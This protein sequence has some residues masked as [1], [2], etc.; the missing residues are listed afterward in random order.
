MIRHAKSFYVFLIIALL[1]GTIPVGLVPG[2]AEAA[3]AGRKSM[4]AKKTKNA[5]VI[6]GQL[7]DS[8]W[9]IDQPLSVRTGD[10]VFKESTF[11]L[12]WDNQYLYIGVKADDDTLV[13]N[14]AGYWFEQDNI[15]LFFD[16]TNHRSAPFASE[17]MQVGFV[18]QPGS[19]TP[20]FHFG[21]ALNNHSGKD[22]KKILHAIRT[23]GSGWTLE[24][25]VPW[26][27]LQLDPRRNKQFGLE[28]G[29]TDRY[30]AADSAKQR[31]S[32]WSA[33]NTTSFWNDT[34]GYGTVTLDDG[35]P[36]TGAVNPVLLHETFD[37][38]PS[39]QL[40]VGW[41][42]DVN[43][44]SPP[45]TVE[46]DTYG[47]GRVV[48]D[49]SASGKQGR[50]IAPVQWDNYVIEA[51][52]RFEKVLDAGRWASLMFRGAASGKAPY[53]QMAVR[54]NGTY[55]I[56]Y[57]KPDNGWF[58]PTPASGM[59][60]PLA[61]N[62]DYTM[63]VRVFDNNVKE[64]IKAKSDSDFTL[65]TDKTLS[66]N[67]L[68]ERG[69]IGLQADQSKVSFDNVK[70]TRITADR[71]D[72]AIPPTMEA[73]TGPLSVTG[74]VYFSDGVT[75]AVYSDR[76][77]L[78]SSDE[79]TI[80]I[81]DGKLYPVKAGK[82]TIHSI[83]ANAEA[84]QEV[85][86]TPSAVGA[87]VVSLKHSEGYVLG[88]A[89]ETIGLESIVF[90]SE[91]SD[92]TSGTLTGDRLT[93]S[94][95]SGGIAVEN[96]KIHVKQKG[97][98]KLT[99]SI[100]SA[101][102]SFLVVAKEAGDAEYVLYEENFDALPD[103]V[104]PPGWT[105]IEGTTPGAAVV[106]A[107]AF[108]L[109]AG[110]APDNPSRVL[111]P[112]HLKL[113]GNYKIEADVTQL[114]A[115]DAARWHSI[116]FRIQNNDYPYY[117]MAVRKDATASNG[118]EFAERTPANAWNV[119]DRGSNSEAIDPAKMYR[120]TVKAY[121]NR[122]QELIDNRVIV[123]TDAAS[124][125]AKGGIGL[126]ANGSSMK[127]D[128]LRI[129]LQQ[130]TLPPMPTDRFVN[131]TEPETKISLAPSVVK[132]VRSAADLASLNGPTL[133]A[134][135]ILHVNRELKVT[136]PAGASELGS[137]DEAMASLGNRM[138][139]AFYVKD[140]QAAD[141]LTGYV[142]R[143]E[144]EDA[145]VVSDRGELVKRV[146][147]A[148]P[149]IRGIVDYSGVDNLTPESLLD[150]RRNTTVHQAKIAILP[151][152]AASIGNVAYLQQ[153][154]IG[155]WAKETAGAADKSVS[156][157]RLIT[158][159]TN[160]IVTDSPAAA[161]DALKVYSN[162]TTLVRKPYVIGHRGIPSEA[163]ENT[164][165]SN[166][167]AVDYGSDFIENDMYV[168]TDDHLVIIHDAVLQNTTSGFG[169]VE[170][171]ALEQ[172]KALNASKPKPGYRETKVPTLDEQIELA[173]RR[174]IMIYAEIKTS[175]P[176]AVD[177]LVKLIKEKNAEHL[178]NVMSFDPNQ[179][180]RFAEQMPGMPLGLLHSGFD[181]S[182]VNKS[183]RE[184]LKIVQ[185]QNVTYNVGYTGLK[186]DYMEAAKHRGIFISPWTINSEKDYK[187]MFA[188]GAYGL[189]TDYASYS[190]NWAASVLPEKDNYVLAQNESA[191]VTAQVYSYAREKTDVAPEIILLDGQDVVD[192]NGGKVTAKKTGTAHAL[193]RYT[194]SMD[195]SSKYDLYT[196]PVT[197]EVKGGGNNGGGNNGGGGNDGGGD[198]GGGN[199]GGGDNGGGNNDGGGDN[200]GGNNGG[201]N[202]GGGDNGGG[203]DS[204]DDN[205]STDSTGGKPAD[206][207]GKHDV[208]AAKP[209]SVVEASGGK[210]AADALKEAF[211]NNAGV[212]VKFTGD[213]LE[214]PAAG[215]S[216]A[217]RKNG[218]TLAVI[219]DS[220]RYTL[221]LDALKLEALAQQLGSAVSD[222][223]IRFTI[224]KLSAGER[225]EVK[226]AANGATVADGI[227]LSVEA[228]N[229][230]GRTVPVSFGP[231]PTAYQ[232]LLGKAV[233]RSKATGVLY[234]PD[235]KRVRFV[236]TLFETRNGQTA[237]TLK[238]SGNGT[239]A[240]IEM[241]KSFADMA[242]HWAQADVELLA[243]KLVVEGVSDNRFEGD[244]P[245]TRSEFAAL[246]VRA[247]G[248]GPV[249]AQ[250]G[251][252]DVAAGAWYAE[253]VAAAAAAGLI[254]GYED[255]SFRPDRQ[256]KREE[257]AAM[258][259]R[260]MSYA[261]LEI[262]V[263]QEKQSE[264]LAPFKD[265]GS[266][267]WAKAEVAAAIHAG[268]MNG[269][270][271]ETLEADGLATRAQSAVMLKRFLIKAS[272]IN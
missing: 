34:S 29:T 156:I 196:Q 192:V 76:L 265:A 151:Q 40:P 89:G 137:L 130:E 93:W 231:A 154:L 25:A 232:L 100:G 86:V 259:I 176:R 6:D 152:R 5:P 68:L 166:E 21:A 22:E 249:T 257:Q 51:D 177:V 172:I 185:K 33:Y 244:R 140:E 113:F 161:F 63:K 212:E 38:D 157:H 30:D 119:T 65:L 95:G 155:V 120:Y 98:H 216:D 220:G 239:Y 116:M 219:G 67:V 10:G 135:V 97:V 272:F 105:R 138:I 35:H 178:L 81:V 208:S 223:S 4:I 188:M 7:D 269:M 227:H 205:S 268:L 256:I 267:G 179:L 226:L 28:V 143:T 142:Q 160:G 255:G 118:V 209:G 187:S 80:R 85:T 213:Q 229:K 233:D 104:L 133:P 121:G 193:L 191:A 77:K 46:Q 240:I 159:G 8:V 122:V 238:R 52:V 16:P 75:E 2:Q 139:P 146:R 71:L 206:G 204:D 181:T 92:F 66:P 53:N 164:L 39:G 20:E 195:A 237:A 153:R 111:L 129:T 99:A 24:A 201:G 266:L 31:S 127:V 158:A 42:S 180:K 124:A 198:N 96:G 141:K 132:E 211:R 107:G 162:Q 235:T 13:S 194:A 221:P 163:P 261:G 202:N 84:A 252:S 174:G 18:Y 103:G 190:K 117:Q 27:M 222:L 173:K 169:K 134:T 125:Y 36:V 224:K 90:Q 37:G 69:K 47:N 64:Y 112:D 114:S 109:N 56:A 12:L 62:N 170:E 144:L 70:V 147:T 73:L 17:D 19:T 148:Y 207:S 44:G 271:V 199:N 88:T 203:S 94:S 184:T 55:E 264:V 15:N 254:S 262:Q 123:D 41:I 23:T 263:S 145:F 83:Y 150:I 168:T 110:A 106:K 101:T 218:A 228:V 49:G 14:G 11:G 243:N 87:K 167:L 214:L 189:T 72:L 171:H 9:S 91:L 78:Y 234:D 253:D 165:E 236:P 43:A 210:V 245:I 108:E 136:D 82:A 250:G 197:F 60:K 225:D 126:Q 217:I 246:L 61:L 131:V 242:N 149:M 241:N 247:L 58:N 48:F 175:N 270:T 183:L 32:Y 260:A 251:F 26:D 128:N 59:W 45:F 230:G 248:L 79:S 54:Q 50:A 200:G 74:S 115:N 258:L 1:S 102:V 186:K 57:R 182:N 3:D 215:L